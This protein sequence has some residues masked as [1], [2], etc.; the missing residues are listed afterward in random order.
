MQRHGSTRRITWTILALGTLCA[1]HA[2]AQK[3]PETVGPLIGHTTS[4]T[5]TLWMYTKRDAKVA[6]VIREEAGGE[7]RSVA[8]E[9]VANPAGKVAGAAYKATI[10]GLKANTRYAYRVT[11][12]GKGDPLR[13]ASFATA[14]EPG[15]PAKFR[16]AVTSCMKIGQPQASWYLLLAQQPDLHVTLGDTQYSDTTNPSV[17]WAHHLRYRALREVATVNRHVPTYAMWDDHDYGPN[18]SDGTAKGKENSL[19]GWKQFWANPPMGTAKT[20]GAFCK[21]TRG[22]VEFFLVDGRYHRS[23]DNAPNDENKR[24]LG[25][26]QFKWLIDGL[27]NSKAKFKVV[28]SGSTLNDSGGDGWKI[29]TFARHRFFDAIKANKIGAVVY[30]SGD[31]HRSRV[32]THHE[33]DR[34]G[35]PLVE[36]IS[37]GVANS[38]TL[39]F[40]TVDFDTTADDPTMRVRI[41]HGDGTARDDKTWKLSQLQVK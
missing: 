39:S 26:A 3:I 31:I 21:F 29:Y 2:A 6:A 10:D 40:A 1:T 9:P 38:K 14:P 32:W 7:E 27:K 22:E 18:N 15:K 24:M 13:S 11:I 12:N 8:F 34:V 36:V 19:A 16:L 35:Y 33:S 41:V 25:D 30:M 37:S 20:P 5:S 23:P 17:Q 28:A 4:T